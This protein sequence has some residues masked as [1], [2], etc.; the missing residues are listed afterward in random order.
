MITRVVAGYL[1][2]FL[3]LGGVALYCVFTMERIQRET[4]LLRRALTGV[5][6][7]FRQ[8]SLDVE[9][10]YSLLSRRQCEQTLVLTEYLP[11]YRPFD[12]LAELAKG[13][14][15]LAREPTLSDRGKELLNEAAKRLSM[16]LNGSGLFDRA[17]AKARAAGA[18]I[19]ETGN[20]E[21]YAALVD[22]YL[23]QARSIQLDKG[24]VKLDMFRRALLDATSS[25][26]KEIK[27]AKAAY[28][29]AL[30]E[31][32][33]ATRGAGLRAV[34]VAGYLGLTALAVVVLVLFFLLSW[35]KPLGKLRRVAQ[36]I[37]MGNYD[38]PA[39]VKRSDEIGELALELNKTA[40]RLKEREEMI[41][42]QA[43]E[44]M[45]AEKFSTIGKMATQIAHEVR[46]P[47][48]ALGLKLELLEET[49]EETGLSLSPDARNEL[50]QA[51][52]SIGRE[53]DR[54]RE[55][56][57]YYLRF[58]KF[59]QV[60]KE[61][62]DVHMLLADTVA[63]Y[64]EEAR[65]KGVSIEQDIEKPMKG[66]VDPG[67]LRHA[68]GNLLKNAIEATGGMEDKKGRII[69]RGW[70]EGA[71]L[72]ITVSDNGLGIPPNELTRVFEPFFSTKKSGTGLGLTL[73]QQVVNE[74]GGKI[75]CSSTPGEGTIFRIWL[76]E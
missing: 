73:V 20:G 47:L 23:A 70:R 42:Q 19:P 40:S 9:Y 7:G 13:I 48:N 14:L 71:Q 5:S 37:A 56:T 4:L 38:Q 30:Q 25:L 58:A 39:E 33:T 60:E 61:L 3:L 8:V 64:E 34:R 59:P 28:S 12:A 63:L 74:H 35:L 36:R 10:V 31:A 72:R 57:D 52:A 41:R 21:T 49:V 62:V 11:G 43:M 45:R 50:R 18:E 1:L 75:S 15:E 29:L 2:V 67:L 32:W 69:V 16:A 65:R 22:G 44:L 6:D 54:L 76:P 68:L 24:G 55:I 46:N 51:V 17:M 26:R 66:R 53:I 27:A